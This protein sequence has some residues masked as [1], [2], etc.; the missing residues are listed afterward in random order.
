MVMFVKKKFSHLLSVNT[1]Q[2][3]RWVVSNT[4]VTMMIVVWTPKFLKNTIMGIPT[5]ST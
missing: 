5:T 4:T 3:K 2:H 1:S